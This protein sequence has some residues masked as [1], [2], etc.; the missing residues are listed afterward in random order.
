ME[1]NLP[2]NECQNFNLDLSNIYKA[3]S[4]DESFEFD[5]AEDNRIIIDAIEECFEENV[6]HA[7][8]FDENFININLAKLLKHLLVNYNFKKVGLIF[9]NFC[10]YFDLDYNQTYL[11]LQYKLQLLV[12]NSVKQIIG[13]KRFDKLKIKSNHGLKVKTLFDIIKK[14]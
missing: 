11:K 9:I 10:D 7:T 1:H 8:K 12:E 2:E 6:K 4:I 3:L 14:H 5:L 13:M